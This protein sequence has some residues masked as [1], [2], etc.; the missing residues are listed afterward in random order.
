[1][2]KK[3]VLE[4]RS[5]LIAS[6]VILAAVISC[7]SKKVVQDNSQL[8]PDAVVQQNE[9]GNSK[10]TSVVSEP[11]AH[12][13]FD[14][15]V[16]TKAGKALVKD[17]ALQIKKS[18]HSAVVVVGGCDERGSV[19]YNQNLGMRRARSVRA[20]LQKWGVSSKNI[21]VESVGKSHPIAQGHDEQSWAQ[22]RRA[23]MHVN[24]KT[25]LANR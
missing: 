14:S 9:P 16:L 24:I 7:T 10:S 11:T 2:N 12:F 15:A 19:A 17:E 3:S 21:K 22:N 4:P 20:E 8:Q 5:L 6:V 13:P 18:G 1:M 25:P 23:V